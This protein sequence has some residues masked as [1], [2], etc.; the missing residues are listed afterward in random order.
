MYALSDRSSK[1]LKVYPV[2]NANTGMTLI[3]LEHYLTFDSN[4]IGNKAVVGRST[5]CGA[6]R[7]VNVRFYYLRLFWATAGV[8]RQS[9]YCQK[10][11]YSLQDSKTCRHADCL[12]RPFCICAPFLF[13]PMECS[14]TPLVFTPRV[15]VHGALCRL[16]PT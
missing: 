15:L 7:E 9:P 5:R 11:L 12:F 10:T 13:T 16:K 14:I 6:R 2:T 3:A 8:T 1:I 4:D